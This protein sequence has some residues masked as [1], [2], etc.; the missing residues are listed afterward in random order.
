MN[1]IKIEKKRTEFV[2]FALLN[3]KKKKNIEENI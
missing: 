2:F 1:V 3:E